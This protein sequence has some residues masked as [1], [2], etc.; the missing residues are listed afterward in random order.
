M[1]TDVPTD[2]DKETV[3]LM[4]EVGA[5]LVE[6]L[7]KEQYELAH[8]AGALHIPLKDIDQ[9]TEDRLKRDEPVI[10]YCYDYQ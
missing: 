7:S 2:I 5:Q 3:R 8:L 1:A 10:V 6:V 9:L 4:V